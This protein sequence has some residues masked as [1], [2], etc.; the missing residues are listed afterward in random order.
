MVSTAVCVAG[1]GPRAFPR[2]RGLMGDLRGAWGA[3]GCACGVAVGAIRA[4][5]RFCLI[6][7]QHATRAM[8]TNAA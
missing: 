6:G 8:S 1:A 2:P 4:I 5:V 7:N 3:L